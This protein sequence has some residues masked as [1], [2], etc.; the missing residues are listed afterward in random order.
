MKT[1][2]VNYEEYY[3]IDIEAKNEDEARE[4]AELEMEN[5]PDKHYSH[6]EIVNVEEKDW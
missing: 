3:T 5:C 1:F 2:R 4:K 6:S